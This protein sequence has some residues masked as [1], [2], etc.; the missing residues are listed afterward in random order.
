[1]QTLTHRLLRSV[2][3]WKKSVKVVFVLGGGLVSALANQFSNFFPAD[4]RWAFWLTQAFAAILIFTG[5]FLE[6]AINENAADTLNRANNLVELLDNCEDKVS[7]L[8]QDFRWFTRLYVIAGALRDIVENVFVC[9][10]GDYED[11]VR[12]FGAMLDVVVADKATLFGI[13]SDRWNFAVYVFNPEADELQCV[14]CRRPTRAEEIADH[15]SWKPGHGHVG[16]A[17]QMQREIVAGDT[18]A[19]EAKAL[20]DSSDVSRQESDR[21]RYRSIASL[22]IRLADEPVVGILVATS[23]IPQRFRLRQPTEPA[24]DPVEPLRILAN[25]LA[26]V[27]KT[28]DFH[29]RPDGVDK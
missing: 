28:N 8:S 29:P 11:Q 24:M 17:F 19:P 21:R 7:S 26:F 13:D 4:Y 15:R 10:P 12:R 14:A 25:A 2:S 20:F 5:A 27:M 16:A 3:R 1:M 22:P 9:G 6:E 23:D 18:S